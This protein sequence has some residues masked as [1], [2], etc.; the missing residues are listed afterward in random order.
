VPPPRASRSPARWLVPAAL[1]VVALGVWLW[2]SAGDADDADGRAAG[3]EPGA[4]SGRPWT[5]P[6]RAPALAGSASPDDRAVTATDAAPAG[7]G[8]GRDDRP[9]GTFHAATD[10]TADPCTAPRDPAVPPEYAVFVAG[11]VTVAWSTDTVSPYQ[12]PIHPT[13][14]AGAVRGMIDEAAAATGTAPRAELTIVLDAGREAYQRRTGAPVWSGGFWSGGEIRTYA[15]PLTDLGVDGR[16]LRHEVMHAQI[17]A[18]VGCVP[19]WLH[20]GLAQLFD[21]A[22]PTRDL[23]ALLRDRTGP[24]PARLG[25]SSLRGVTDDTAAVNRAYAMALAMVL[26]ALPRGRADDV[27]AL[28]ATARGL[29]DDPAA[30]WD[31][32]AG[33]AG[34]AVVI[35]MLAARTFGA[36]AGAAT[37]LAAGPLCCAGLYDVA[38]L[39][40][41]AAKTEPPVKNRMWIESDDATGAPLAC[42]ATW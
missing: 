27:A 28:I 34:A 24:E 7:P 19:I 6:S 2:R 36:A 3:D 5:A 32:V 10:H 20:E 40:C 41:R 30:V 15:E 12:A 16:T 4:G 1:L 39:R 11:G 13:V 14:I 21:G 37:A 17:H 33:G 18:A 42:R 22:A 35:E 9:P 8:S 25:G 31:R 23:L 26:Y 29:R 38:N